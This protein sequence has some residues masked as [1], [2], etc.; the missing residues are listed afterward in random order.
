MRFWLEIR[1]ASLPETKDV[2]MRLYDGVTDE[3]KHLRR[4]FICDFLPRDLIKRN[5][6]EQIMGAIE[7]ELEKYID[8]AFK[9]NK[10]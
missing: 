4:Q 9:E 8:N 5:L 7:V 6:K 10:E 3:W 1:D 2:E